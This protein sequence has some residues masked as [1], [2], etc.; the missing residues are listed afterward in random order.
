MI[1]F[2]EPQSWASTA[3]LRTNEA[4]IG[5]DPVTLSRVSSSPSRQFHRI[6]GRCASPSRGSARRPCGHTQQHQ[7]GKRVLAL[8]HSRGP[9]CNAEWPFFRNWPYCLSLWASRLAALNYFWRTH[10]VPVVFQTWSST[11]QC[12]VSPVLR[13][14]RMGLTDRRSHEI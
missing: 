3:P 7:S 11:A 2:Y 13:S 10:V 9:F 5:R 8:F 6:T 1:G 4:A 12:S 14:I